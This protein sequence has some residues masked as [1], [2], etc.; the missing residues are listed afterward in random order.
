VTQATR[1]WDRL[2]HR[3]IP[4]FA[5]VLALLLAGQA[6]AQTTR[7]DELRSVAQAH[8]KNADW[9]Q[10]CRTYDEMIRHDRT[11]VEAREG[12]HRCFRQYQIVRRH[13]DPLYRESLTHLK[14]SDALDIYDSVVTTV[15][16]TYYAKTDL[17]ALFRNGVQEVRYALGQNSFIQAHMP[18]ASPD[19]VQ[20]FKARLANWP[21]FKVE[22]PGKVRGLVVKL[23]GMAH[24]EKLVHEKG[25]FAIVIA[26]EFAFGTCAGLDEYSLF[27]TPGQQALLDAM[28]RGKIVSVGLELMRTA[29]GQPLEVARAYPKGP[30][31]GLLPHD[32]ILQIDQQPTANMTPERAAELLRGE[33]GSVVQL[34]VE[35]NGEKLPALNLE[36]RTVTVPS[37]DPPVMMKDGDDI[38]YLR[39]THFQETTPDEV[40]EALAE[41]HSRGMKSLIIDLR[42]NPGGSVP[43]AIKVAEIFLPEG[44]IV[45]LE[46]RHPEFNGAVSIKN[47]MGSPVQMPTAV[48]ID[49]DT[50]SAAELLAGALKEN[51]STTLLFG[52]TTF[53]KGSVQ[54]IIPLKK[55]PGGIRI[56]IAKFTSPQKQPYANT[57]IAPTFPVDPP[58]QAHEAAVR[59]L[60]DAMQRMKMSN[61]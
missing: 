41:L 49:A 22:D 36:R 5:G 53:G 43:A 26:L 21:D 14:L 9:V 34:I 47:M 35:R 56:T 37:V 8:E 33:P 24:D 52:E 3:F 18:D 38:G 29:D 61:M 45:N 39:I 1:R 16:A 2:P 48:L 42:G 58:T 60:M 6:S 51:S 44:V 46:S 10:A 4:L 54:C 31:Y 25:S 57:G 23:A 40:R 15:T 12:Y 55:T 20:A 32:R 28:L 30:A 50:A 11:S 59:Y 19:A 17:N 13:T 7:L 27:L